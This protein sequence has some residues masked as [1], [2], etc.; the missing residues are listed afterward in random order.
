MTYFFRRCK[1]IS[2]CYISVITLKSKL[3]IFSFQHSLQ[4]LT[5]LKLFFK[6]F[7]V[8]P[9]WLPIFS[10]FSL[11]YEPG[12]GLTEIDPGMTYTSFSIQYWMDKIRTHNISIKSRVRY[13]LDRTFA[14]NLDPFNSVLFFLNQLGICSFTCDS[15]PS[16]SHSG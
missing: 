10:F 16:L 6:F 3:F 2:F 1:L 4:I 13:P 12:L 8:C 7:L 15:I 11:L 14:H 5:P 9:I